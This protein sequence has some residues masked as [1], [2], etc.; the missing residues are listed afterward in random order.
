VTWSGSPGAASVTIAGPGGNPTMS[1]S[2][3]VIYDRTS[4]VSGNSPPINIHRVTFTLS[5]PTTST[6]TAYVSQPGATVTIEVN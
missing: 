6:W 1:E 4:Y 2:G 5:S 3:A